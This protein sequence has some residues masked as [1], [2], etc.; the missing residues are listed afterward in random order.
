MPLVDFDLPL[1][2]FGKQLALEMGR[3]LHGCCVGSGL[4]LRD[5][6]CQEEDVMCECTR[7]VANKINILK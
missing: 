1:L 2:A 6:P 4:G 7:N 3:A 5:L